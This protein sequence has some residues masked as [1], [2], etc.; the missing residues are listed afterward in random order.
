MRE[1]I[2]KILYKFL[3]VVLIACWIFFALFSVS[4]CYQINYLY[5]LKYKEIVVERA[6]YY[7]LDRALIFAVIK[8]ESGFN[9]NAKSKAG[10]KGLMQITEKTAEYIAQRLCLKNYDIMNVKTNVNF[11]CYYIKYLL[12]RFGDLDTALIA[13]NAGEG[14]VASWLT[15]K[16]YSDDGKSLKNTPYQESNEYIIK[17]HKNF[18]KY[19]KLYKKILDK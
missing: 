3:L 9:A 6:D 14:K 11:G 15:D 16:N 10:A 5:P 19:K 18:K 13:Y 12:V 7:G 17:I 8:T 2:G 1:K 4:T